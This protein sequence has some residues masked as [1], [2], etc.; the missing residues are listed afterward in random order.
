MTDE[1]FRLER[2]APPAPKPPIFLDQERTHQGKLFDDD[3]TEL[4]GQTH[5]T[6]DGED[7]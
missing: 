7:E 6:F 2:P 5:F 1:P 4:P 3:R